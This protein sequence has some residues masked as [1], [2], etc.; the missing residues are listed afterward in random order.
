MTGFF[1]LI[2]REENDKK[3]VNE[4]AYEHQ[5]NNGSFKQNKNG[6][7]ASKT[8]YWRSLLKTEWKQ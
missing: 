8:S 1:K 2:I 5:N 3:F 6:R 7:G 4:T